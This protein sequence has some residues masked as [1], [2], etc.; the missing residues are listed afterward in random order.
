M[1]FSSDT[2][3]TTVLSPLEMIPRRAFLHSGVRNVERHTRRHWRFSRRAPRLQRR[4]VRRHLRLHLRRLLPRLFVRLQSLL[5]SFF[6]RRHV[7]LSARFSLRHERLQRRSC[8]HALIDPTS[9]LPNFFATFEHFFFCSSHGV[10]I[11]GTVGPA[12][13]VRTI[14]PECS[15]LSTLTEEAMTAWSCVRVIAIDDG[16]EAL[17]VAAEASAKQHASSSAT[18]SETGARVFILIATRAT[19]QRRIV[20][21][22]V[23]RSRNCAVL[24]DAVDCAI[25]CSIGGARW[26]WCAR[27]KC[28]TPKDLFLYCSLRLNSCA[29]DHTLHKDIYFRAPPRYERSRGGRGIIEK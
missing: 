10:P 1:H 22:T 2:H 13:T 16:S 24:D 15:D 25:Y 18:H 3:E 9:P 6:V 27:W 11:V 26:C 23:A 7:R 29:S 4:L 17:I 14:G 8:L 12:G 19:M 20:E 21:I 28:C 5:H